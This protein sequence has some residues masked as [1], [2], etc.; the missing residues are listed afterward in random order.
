[1]Q[2]SLFSTIYSPIGK[3]IKH[4]A[5]VCVALFLLSACQEKTSEEFMQEA[6]QFIAAGDKQAAVVA[7]K[8]AVQKNVRS[9]D[10]RFK[11]GKLHLE[12]EDYASAEKELSRAIELGYDESQ[13]LPLLTLALQR[14]GANVELSQLDIISSSIS[15]DEKVE[16]GFRQLASLVALNKEEESR[17]LISSLLEIQSDSAYRNLVQAYLYIFDESAVEAL[18]EAELAYEKEPLNRDVINTA[19][20]LYTL[21]GQGEKGAQLYEEYLKVAPND[22]QAKFSIANMLIEQRQADRAEVYIDELLSLNENSP[23]LTQLKAVVRAAVKDYAAAKEFAEKSISMGNNNPASRLI[24]G[25]SSYEL[26]EFEAAVGHLTVIASILPDNHPGLRILAASQLQS[27]MGDEAGEILQRVIAADS[28]DASLFSRAGYELIKSG[29]IDGAKSVIEQAEKVTESSEDLARLGVL[30][31]SINDVEGVVNL[32]S[33][34]AQA[35]ESASARATLAG[36]YLS[37]EQ[38]DKALSLSREWQLDSPKDVEGY[39][40]ESEVLQRQSRF[41]EASVVINKAKLIDDSVLPVR[42]T[43]VRLLLR[44]ENYQAAVDKLN[45]LIK[46]FPDNSAVLASYFAS[47][48]ELGESQEAEQTVK[49]IVSRYPDN[50]DLALLYARVAVTSKNYQAAADALQNIPTDRSAPPNFWPI[51]GAALLRSNNLEAAETHYEAWVKNYPNKANAILGRLVI[52]DLKREFAEGSDLANE[53]LRS[54]DNLQVKI[55]HSYFL[56]MN[57]DPQRSRKIYDSL[58]DKYKALPFLRGVSA[59]LAISEGRAAEA[60][61]DAFIA[62][63]DNKNLNNLMVYLNT[64]DASNNRTQAINTIEKHVELF[65]SDARPKLLLG[66]RLIGANPDRALVVYQDILQD[67]PTN[68]VVLNNVAYLEM[69]A[70][71]LPQAEEYARRALEIEANSVAIA[72]TLGQILFKQNKPKEALDV[73]NKV[74]TNNV[75]NEEI[76]LNYI[77]LLL[78]NGNKEVAQRRIN[79]LEVQ[80]NASKTRLKNLENTYLN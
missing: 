56:V 19:A 59:R 35:P 75:K 25:L 42:L 3:L 22:L 54:R 2:D 5:L 70:G 69:Q 18:N 32:E 65:P 58:D 20:R 30:K 33:A 45:V 50:A 68:F 16:A 44:Q 52:H 9:A 60:V 43:E 78:V 21:N 13:V 74:M 55:M 28:S 72:D 77:E 11:L 48:V 46:D 49:E 24:A 34:V 27:N 71:N 36:A 63:E 17:S 66:E 12:L 47:K 51:K 31:L 26:Q 6:Q 29:D 76:L 38:Y 73:Y 67:F 8:N 37:T 57:R 40:L 62:Y 23:E 41:A 1:M 61:Q 10:A 39:V 80:S 79:N 15:P 14:S 64:L 7:M 53:F 4:A